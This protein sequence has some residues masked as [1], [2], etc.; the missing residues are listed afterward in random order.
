MPCIAIL[1]TVRG[2]D[3]VV[4]ILCSHTH[5][6]V[7]AFELHGGHADEGPG[8]AATRR[9]LARICIPTQSLSG[10]GQRAST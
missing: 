6:V 7:P 2:P 3:D 10:L 1:A 8:I 4:R 9:A 5:V